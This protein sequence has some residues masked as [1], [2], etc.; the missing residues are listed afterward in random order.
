M[1]LLAFASLARASSPSCGGARD[2]QRSA[3]RRLSGCSYAVT[4]SQERLRDLLRNREGLDKR[5]ASGT[6]TAERLKL[7]IGGRVA[8]SGHRDE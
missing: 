3:R 5:S 8:I 6:A 1:M 2:A 4:E 7:P